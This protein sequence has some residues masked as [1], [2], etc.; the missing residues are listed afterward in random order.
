[1]RELNVNE[2]EEVN[3]GSI[4]APEPVFVIVNGEKMQVSPVILGS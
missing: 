3:G 2:M 1:M 4:D